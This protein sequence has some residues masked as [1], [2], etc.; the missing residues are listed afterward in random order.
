[1]KK[2]SLLSIAL[3]AMLQAAMLGIS[4]CGMTDAPV[5][6]TTSE[7]IT[8]Y[9]FK[10]THGHE[11]T[12]M[13][14]DKR[15]APGPYTLTMEMDGEYEDTYRGKPMYECDWYSSAMQ[16]PG[17]YYHGYYAMDEQG[18]YYMGSNPKP[19][20]AQ[21]LWLDLVAPIKQGQK[22]SF[23]YGIDPDNTINAEI[24]K[25]GVTAALA[26]STG[27]QV[28]YTDVI[29]VVYQGAEDKTV[30]WFA[31]DHAMLAEWKYNAKGEIIHKKIL[32]KYES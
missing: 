17:D 10:L 1:M 15:F 21:G 6:P 7:T 2:I 20:P 32:W 27:K 11:Y 22:W 23:A 31:R 12:Y 9:Y 19:E 24:T 5:E 30:K 14:E 28:T 25:M 13:V 4:G 8:P 29:E 3:A 18:A 26:D 16:V